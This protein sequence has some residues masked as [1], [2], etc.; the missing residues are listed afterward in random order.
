MIFVSAY[1]WVPIFTKKSLMRFRKD[2]SCA[3]MQPFCRCVCMCVWG[4]GATTTTENSKALVKIF[5]LSHCISWK[6]IT[7]QAFPSVDWS[8]DDGMLILAVFKPLQQY[9]TCLR[10]LWGIVWPRPSSAFKTWDLLC[11]TTSGWVQLTAWA[12]LSLHFCHGKNRPWME[13]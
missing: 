4:V 8:W 9:L 1:R 5:Y 3:P 6:T 11:Q 12:W 10:L 13:L 7:K 2:C